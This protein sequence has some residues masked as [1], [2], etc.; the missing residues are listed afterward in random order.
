MQNTET[1]NDRLSPPDFF[2]MGFIFSFFDLNFHIFSFSD[3]NVTILYFA[4]KNTCPFSSVHT[5]L[6]CVCIMKRIIRATLL[7]FGCFNFTS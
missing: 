5:A 2:F 7:T 4:N 3:H 1:K 6:V